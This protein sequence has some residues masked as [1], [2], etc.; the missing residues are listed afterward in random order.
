M[1]ANL[2]GKRR[3]AASGKAIADLMLAPAVIMLRLPVMVAEAGGTNRHDETARAISE[4]VAATAEGLVAA[5]LSMASSIA[6]F[7]PELMAGQAPSILNGVALERS[8]H[9]A[10]RPAGLRVKANFK[11]LARQ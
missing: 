5:Q 7:W 9:A 1:K 2:Q 6:N 3:G 8:M 11:R 10:L 4:K